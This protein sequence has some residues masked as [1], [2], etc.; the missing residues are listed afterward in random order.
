MKLKLKDIAEYCGGKLFGDGELEVTGF[1]TDSRQAYKGGMFVPIK[2]ERVDGHD[3]IPNVFN[4]GCEATFSQKELEGGNYVLVEDSRLA[5]QK[6]AAAWRSQFDIPVIGITGSVGKTTTKEIVSL[7]LESGLNVLKTAGN[8]NSQIGLPLTVFRISP[9][10][11]CAILE[12]G[13]SMPGEMGRISAA[14]KV[15]MAIITTIGTSHIEFHGTKEN[16]LK[17]KLHIADY[18]PEGGII[19]VNGDD[20]LLA[21][22][23]AKDSRVRTFGLAE[24]CDYRA[25]NSK[26]YTDRSEFTYRGKKVVMPSP[27]THNIRNALAALAATEVLGL[28]L[29]KAIAALASYCPPEMRQQIKHFGDITVIDDCYNASPDSMMSALQILGNYEGRRIAVLADMLELG[30]YSEKGHR[31]VG[32]EAKKKATFLVAAGK[33][34][35]YIYEG[36]GDAENSRYFETNGEANKFLDGFVKEGDTVLVKGSR[37]MHTE[38]VVNFLKAKFPPAVVK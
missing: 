32:A 36:F 4:A 27:G 19:L 10:H 5:L 24:N 37:G 22:L 31:E 1:F 21:P 29:E 25:E 34:A 30:D 16:I 3:F 23:K 26:E 20:A 9:E 38:E 14:A 6:T 11:E 33:E 18:I 28:D 2:G 17:E 13:M 8:A 12:M 15:N 7:A 35:K